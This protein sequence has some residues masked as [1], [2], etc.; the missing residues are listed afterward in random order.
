MPNGGTVTDIQQWEVINQIKATDAEQTTKIAILQEA[1][2]E[3]DQARQRTHAMM[4]WIA[5]LAVTIISAVMTYVSTIQGRVTALETLVHKMEQQITNQ[6]KEFGKVYDRV[7]ILQTD[8]AGNTQA[9]DGLKIEIQ[10]RKDY[11]VRNTDM[12]NDLSKQV[13]K[14]NVKLIELVK[15]N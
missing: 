10:D 8:T 11:S 7:S 14:D 3:C 4:M 12:I 5:G 9:I 6:G 13:N 1:Q 15:K 2:R